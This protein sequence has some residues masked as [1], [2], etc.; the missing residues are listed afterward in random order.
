MR[1]GAWAPSGRPASRGR[2]RVPFPRRPAG[3]TAGLLLPG[4]GRAA[5][6][7]AALPPDRVPG[8]FLGILQGTKDGGGKFCSHGGP[9]ASSSASLIVG[10]ATQTI[11][12]CVLGPR[13]A[14]GIL[15]LQ[16]ARVARHRGFRQAIFQKDKRYRRSY[17]R[18]GVPRTPS[19][20][21]VSRSIRGRIFDDQ[22]TAGLT[23][24]SPPQV[25][26][27]GCFLRWPSFS[28]AARKRPT[29]RRFTYPEHAADSR[30]LCA[31]GPG[32]A[33]GRRRPPGQPRCRRKPRSR[34]GQSCAW[35]R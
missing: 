17:D 3:A 20:P 30:G 33:A 9:V 1:S 5:D 29:C 24:G 7:P 13:R 2:G 21:S 23:S 18:R 11:A 6:V 35:P 10:S 4:E 14:C 25:S 28:R 16:R 31:H 15:R 22:T 34:P 19:L 12:Y 32:R 27:D 8:P 26:I